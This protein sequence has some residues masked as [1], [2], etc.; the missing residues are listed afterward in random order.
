MK[1]TSKSSILDLEAH[2]SWSFVLLVAPD[3]KNTSEAGKRPSSGTSVSD[4]LM[5][6]KP[7]VIRSSILDLEVHSSW[8][9]V[10]LA[11]P[12]LKKTSEME[13]P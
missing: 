3:L 8:P 2:S 10:L 7:T 9:F 1:K 6:P 5:T 4:E 11:A 12:D 13:K